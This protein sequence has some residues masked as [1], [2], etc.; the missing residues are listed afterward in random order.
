MSRTCTCCS[1]ITEPHLLLKCCVCQNCFNNV[2][3]GITSS[4]TRLINGKKSLS[5]TCNQCNSI[6]ND[7]N[8]LK[9]AI[10]SLQNEIKLIT[11]THAQEGNPSNNQF[12]DIVQEVVERQN[13][14][15]NVVIFGVAEQK[16]L[17]KDERINAEKTDVLKILTFLLPSLGPISNIFRL[18]KYNEQRTTPRPIKV[19]AANSQQVMEVLRKSGNLKNNENLKHIRLVPDQ[20]PRQMEYY[21]K[22]KAELDQRKQ[23]GEENIKIK[24]ING[25]PKIINF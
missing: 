11:T 25:V 6:G 14:K 12:E 17:T 1:K 23:A 20:T 18:G 5:W 22:I 8:S 15:A 21:K 16:N 9:A 2:C 7:I 19:T 24:H 4:E 10:V 13:R 3:V